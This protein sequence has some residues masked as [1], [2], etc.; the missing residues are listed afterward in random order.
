MQTAVNEANIIKS[1]CEKALSEAMPALLRAEDAL[2]VL[3]RK[4]IDVL[5]AMKN[6]PLPIKTVM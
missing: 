4:D 6:P 2:K 3:D 5:K 1:E